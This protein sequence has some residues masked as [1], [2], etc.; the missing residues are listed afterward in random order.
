MNVR[1]LPEDALKLQKLARLAGEGMSSVV[2][3]LVRNEYDVK[4]RLKK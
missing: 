4:F 1:M 3:T 2:R